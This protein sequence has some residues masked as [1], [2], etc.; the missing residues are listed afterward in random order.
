MVPGKPCAHPG[1]GRTRRGPAPGESANDVRAGTVVALSGTAFD[2]GG[3][4]FRLLS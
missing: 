4:A 1:P 3:N 2:H